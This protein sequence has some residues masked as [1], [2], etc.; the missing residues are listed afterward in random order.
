[1]T[2]LTSALAELADE[3]APPMRLDLDRAR[4]AGRRRRR[5]RHCSIAGG[6]AVILAAG[7][8]LPQVFAPGEPPDQG[9]ALPAAEGASTEHNPLRAYA[10]FGWLPDSIAGV[11]Y[12][13]GAHGDNTL[14]RGLGEFPA[15]I[16]LSVYDEEPGLNGQQQ[17]AFAGEPARV[18]AE[19][20]GRQGY[21]LTADARDPING[22]DSYLRWQTEDGRWAELNAYYLNVPDPQQTLLRVAADVTF[23]TEPVPLPLRISE[24]PANFRV[25]DALLSRPSGPDGGWDMQLIYNVNGGRVTID[26][27]PQDQRGMQDGAACKTEKGLRA[28]VTVHQPQAVEL[29]RIGGVQGVLDRITLLGL[30]ERDW[31]TRVVG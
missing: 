31:T 16:W 13:V 1:M 2:D 9:V 4:R 11:G 15:Y 6:A 27:Q 24:L 17:Q 29:D 10:D 14:A 28:C 21:W 26:V 20:G 12:A 25:E 19:V 3:P 5:L 8:T 30:D 7:L 18:P 23:G 22:G